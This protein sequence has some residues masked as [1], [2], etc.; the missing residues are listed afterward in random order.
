MDP[1][2]GFC[3]ATRTFRSLRPAIA[4]PPEDAPVSFPS[5]ALSRLPSPLPAHPALVDAST[6]AA[7]SFA[8]LLALVRS[9]AAALRGAL[10]V[11]RGDVALVLAP[12]SLDVPVVYLAVLSVGAVVSP[13]SPLS[14]A[15]DVA[16]AVGLCR[17]SVVFANAATVGK[18]PAART[19]LTVVLLDS[20]QFE[21]F[22]HGHEPVEADGPPAEVRQSDVA[23]ISY[24]SGTTGRTKAVAQPHR[25]LIASSLQVPS[26]RPRAPGGHVVTLLGVP[27]FHSYGFHMLMRGVAAAETT[28]VVTAPRSGAAA[29]L[30]AAARCRATQMFVAPP[31]VVAMARG[32]VGGPEGFPDLVRVDCGGAPLSTAAASSFQERFPDVELSLALGSTEGGV[33]S[34]MV[35][36]Q[37]CHRIK[38]T[39]R[40]CSGVEAKVVDIIS[41][42][43][44]STNEQ[45]ELCIRS[46][47]VMLGYVGGNETRMSAFDS[48]GWLKTGDL[49]YFDEDGFLYVVDRLKDLIKYN[50]YQVAPAELEDVLHLIPGIFDAAVIPYPDEEA[51]QLPMAFVVRQNGSNN[52]TED[53]IMEFVA[54]RV[55]PYKKIRKV[56]FVDSIP[57]LPSG[58][59][60]RRELHKQITLSQSTSRL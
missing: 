7:L 10:G 45:G 33:T 9:L 17:P 49:C 14:T 4:L 11:A 23:A 34:K 18:V 3:P 44:L 21:S 60:L 56:V 51:G 54:K 42:G 15:A 59:L 39:G 40:L 20:P 19:K 13:V 57:R 31:V 52:L 50:A 46:P 32:G 22:L 25:R 28:A 6:G 2:S 37:E 27:M 47:G 5:F 43:L 16:R 41:G 36:H 53:Q 24:S 48:D 8:A 30:A 58:K 26:A 29:V 12:P 1:R 38:S 55:A 35:G